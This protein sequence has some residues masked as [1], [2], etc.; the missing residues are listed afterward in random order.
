MLTFRVDKARNALFI[1]LAGIM[2]KDKIAERLPQMLKACSELSPHFT[3][4]TDL[5]LAKDITD[6]DLKIFGQVA[7]KV[8]ETFEVKQTIRILGTSAQYIQT[9][10]K[11]DATLENITVHYVYTRA[12]AMKFVNKK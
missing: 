2:Q 5:T 8:Y 4:M 9:L 7:K 3:I 10:K 11:I 1:T 12:D 6:T